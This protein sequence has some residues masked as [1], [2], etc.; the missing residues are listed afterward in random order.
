ME[1]S[2]FAN[3]ECFVTLFEH[4][5]IFLCLVDLKDVSLQPMFPALQKAPSCSS[6]FGVRHG[7]RSQEPW[8]YNAYLKR[9]IQRVDEGALK[10]INMHLAKNHGPSP[11]PPKQNN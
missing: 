10:P 6:K 5:F 2:P 1:H 3:D 11:L 8:R 7:I 9:L 4:V